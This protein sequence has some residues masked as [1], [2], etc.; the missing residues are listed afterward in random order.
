MASPEGPVTQSVTTLL[1]PGL[2]LGDDNESP[3]NQE[4]IR[5]N[6]LLKAQPGCLSQYWGHQVENPN[7]FMWLI[8][9]ES[10]P[11]Y[12]TFRESPAHDDIAGGVGKLMQ[13]DLDSAP[14][15]VTFTKWD[16]DA[17]AALKAPVTEFAYFKLPD[18]AGE[19][20]ENECREL[21]STIPDYVTTVGKALGSATG[22]VFLVEPESAKAPWLHGVYGWQDIE[23]HMRWREMPEIQAPVKVFMEAGKKGLALVPAVEVPGINKETGWFHVRFHHDD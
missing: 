4:F 9:W 7:I 10:K 22:W 15:F 11:I 23:A 21:L 19:K 20:E 12:N 18:G 3:E 17:K 13:F 5:L 2:R 6:K 14:V 8:D 16:K 1:K